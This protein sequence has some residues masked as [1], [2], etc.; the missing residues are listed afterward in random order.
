MNQTPPS[1]KT[2]RNHNPGP[3]G[4]ESKQKDSRQ[5]KQKQGRFKAR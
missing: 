4:P 3:R 1:K 5:N 2:Y